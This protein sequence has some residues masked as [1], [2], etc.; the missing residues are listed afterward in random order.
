MGGCGPPHP[1]HPAWTVQGQGRQESGGSTLEWREIMGEEAWTIPHC[2][3]SQ[4]CTSVWAI[5]CLAKQIFPQNYKFTK[6]STLRNMYLAEWIQY[7]AVYRTW[8]LCNDPI[9]PGN[10][11]AVLLLV[12]GQWQ[13]VQHSVVQYA[14][15][16]RPRFFPFHW[17]LES[18]KK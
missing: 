6:V 9:N 18:Q 4:S 12:E 15:L 16:T 1:S 2:S 8:F 11:R 7:S 14:R 17:F 13:F 10:R 3:F 5:T